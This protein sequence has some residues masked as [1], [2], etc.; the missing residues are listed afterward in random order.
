MVC[1]TTT[2]HASDTLK[3]HDDDPTRQRLNIKSSLRPI[4]NRSTQREIN[5]I[6]NDFV[7][8]I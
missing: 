2:Q 5:V 3:D 8:F 6:S 1:G 7:H 4:N